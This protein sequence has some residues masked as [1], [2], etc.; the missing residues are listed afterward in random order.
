MKISAF[1]K[2]NSQQL[3]FEAQHLFSPAAPINEAD[4][5]AGRREEIKRFILAIAERG[6]HVILYGERG[7]GKTS[8]ASIFHFLLSESNQVTH[9]RTQASPDDNYSSLW[10]KVFKDLSYESTEN[11]G[12]GNV[13]T[14]TQSIADLYDHKITSDDVARELRKVDKKTVIIFDEFD[15]INDLETKKLM[16]HTIKLLSDLGINST[17]VIVGVADDVNTLVDEHESVK[18]NLEEIKMPRMTKTELIEIL[19]ERLPR[20]NLGIDKPAQSK[21][22]NLSRGLPEYVHSL[23]KYAAINAIQHKKKNIQDPDVDIAIRT[24]LH[25][26]DQSSNNTYK[27]AIQSNKKN[28]LY[29]PVLLA[30]AL[31]KTDDEGNFV[32]NALIL[33][34]SNILKR[35]VSIPN[36]QANLAE[37]CKEERGKILEK[38][39]KARAFK[40]RFHEPKMQPYIIMKGIISVNIDEKMLKNLLSLK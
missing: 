8:L 5:F 21:I 11:L 2:Q 34:L 39:G 10:R 4:L 6:R 35:N 18:R 38:H 29:E 13:K 32:A 1:K 22:V 12:Y 23:G 24:I 25:Q 20:L 15:K 40:Y 3:A 16:S 30:C 36:F 7:V 9:I 33:P 19:T 27:K 28:T 14:N 37:F 17:I 26:S 31:A